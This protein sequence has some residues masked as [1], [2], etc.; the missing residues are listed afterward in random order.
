MTLLRLVAASLP[1]PQEVLGGLDECRTLGFVHVND[2]GI[3]TLS[4]AGM[5]FLLYVVAKNVNTVAE[6]FAAGRMAA[7]DEIEDET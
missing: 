5:G 2:Q 7:F 6:A 1:L 4:T 3:Q